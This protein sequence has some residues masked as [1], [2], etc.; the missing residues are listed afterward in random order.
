MPQ[1]GI[2]KPYFMKALE[3]QNFE[4]GVTVPTQTFEYEKLCIV[5]QRDKCVTFVK[6]TLLCNAKRQQGAYSKTPWLSF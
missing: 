4:M 6:V 2:P 3:A 5:I 1:Q